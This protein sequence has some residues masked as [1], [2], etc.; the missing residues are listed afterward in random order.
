MTKEIRISISVKR[1]KTFIKKKRSKL[2]YNLKRIRIKILISNIYKIR[3][4]TIYK[5]ISRRFIL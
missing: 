5:R 1:R 2:C 3:R 4:T